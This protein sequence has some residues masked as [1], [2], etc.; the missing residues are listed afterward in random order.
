LF[1]RRDWMSYVL[2][3][4]GVLCIALAA[5]LLWKI[6]ETTMR[7]VSS[8][9]MVQAPAQGAPVTPPGQGVAGKER[10]G[11]PPNHGLA[12]EESR[13]IAIVQKLG[14]R[15]REEIIRRAKD[16]EWGEATHMLLESASV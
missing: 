4:V 3:L 13:V 2:C 16:Q 7:G 12:S 8:W 5:I 9:W 14:E 10:T 11:T 15:V 1:D 6:V